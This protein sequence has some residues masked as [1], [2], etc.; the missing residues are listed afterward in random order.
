MKISLNWLK[1]YVSFKVNPEVLAHKLTM[2]GL[3]VEKIAPIGKDTVFEFEI[4]PNRPDS[5]SFLGIGREVSAVLNTTL[6]I[7]PHKKLKSPKEKV[8]VVVSARNGCR[9]YFAMVIKDVKV[10]E[11]PP[12]LKTYLRAVGLRSINNIVDITNFVLMETGQP[13]HAFDY[14]QL[15]G[16]RIIVRWAAPEESIVAIDEK[17]YKL[18]AS[19]LVI[20]D[21]QRP[22]AIAGIMGGKESEVSLRTKNILLES[23]Y[24]DSLVIR[25]TARTLGLCSDSSYRFERGVDFD[26]VGSWAQRAICLI[27]EMAGGTLSASNDIF[28]GQ[29]KTAAVKIKLS[30]AE[31]NKL[32]GSSVNFGRCKTILS[33]LGFKVTSATKDFLAVEVPSFRRDIKTKVDIIEEIARVI[34]YDNLP[35]SL[36]MVR[37]SDIEDSKS[38]TVR[39]RISDTLVGQGLNEVIS[40]TM[41]SRKVL[42]SCGLDSSGVVAVQNPLSA[43]QE[44]MRPSLLPS[45][46]SVVLA[47]VNKGQKDLRLFETGKIYLPAGEREVLGMVMMGRQHRDWRKSLKDEVDFYDIKGVLER[48]L[49]RLKIKDYLFKPSPEAMFEPG[50]GVSLFIDGQAISQLGKVSD[51]ILAQ[52]D[53]KKAKLYYAEVDL[54]QL[55]AR[56][57]SFGRYQPISE[58]PAITRDISLAVKQDVTF[59]QIRQVA[60]DSGARHLVSVEFIEEYKGEKIIPGY[61]GVVFSLIYQSPVETL[62][63]QQ[64]NQSHEKIRQN[65]I[66]KLAAI[67]R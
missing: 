17:E 24:F 12:W 19:I 11:S 47:N 58:Y 37:M 31:I 34:G 40:L 8:P 39:E 14:D 29:K 20:A 65:L 62:Q 63:D 66:E 54:A 50:Q 45:L 56:A 41:I 49:E 55:Y 4:T 53:I 51:D 35:V 48:V 10:G 23:A 6:K 44:L 9:R 36:P 61:R 27:Q 59:E 42:H 28:T 2:A 21:D 25:R 52:W 38:R 1:E 64:V 3:E 15:I 22:V 30:V 18:D 46:L 16:G 57:V 33:K 13:L 67:P 7:P 43:E 26:S 60:F 32:L 5:L